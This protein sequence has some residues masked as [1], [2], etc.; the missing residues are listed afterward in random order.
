MKS[1]YKIDKNGLYDYLK[2]F[3]SGEG[4]YCGFGKFISGNPKISDFINEYFFV[5]NEGDCYSYGPYSDEA[6][7]FLPLTIT[8][9]EFANIFKR[10]IEEAISNTEMYK[11]WKNEL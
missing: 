5:E 3:Q 1:K 9:T 11:N 4:S 2:E 10:C 8:K 6:W 7:D